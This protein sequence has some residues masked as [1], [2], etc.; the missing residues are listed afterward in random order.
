MKQLT[1]LGSTGSIGCSTLDVVRH[2]PG[3]FSVAALVA[4]KNVCPN[5]G[6]LPLSFY[7]EVPNF[8]AHNYGV[9]PNS[10]I[11]YGYHHLRHYYLLS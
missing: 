7:D 6:A 5:I 8:Y 10:G 2:N 3:R 4:G 1:V 11:S 9:N